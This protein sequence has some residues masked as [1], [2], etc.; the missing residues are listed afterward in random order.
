MHIFDFIRTGIGI[1]S[2]VSFAALL[3]R[4][5]YMIDNT[6][7][8]QNLL[9]CQPMRRTKLNYKQLGDCSPFSSHKRSLFIA[10]LE[11]NTIF[12]GLTFILSS[13]SHKPKRRAANYPKKQ[14]QIFAI[15]TDRLL[16]LQI[17]LI[18][19]LP[20]NGY[21]MGRKLFLL[22]HIFGQRSCSDDQSKMVFVSLK[23]TIW[24]RQTSQRIYTH[25]QSNETE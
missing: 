5:N 16:F 15:Q 3:K 23:I 2:A 7:V 21:L 10:S 17:S 22:Y 14:L 25:Q 4:L 8:R 9:F 20:I 11:R 6:E 24:Y 18:T 13:T 1:N 19:F 12:A